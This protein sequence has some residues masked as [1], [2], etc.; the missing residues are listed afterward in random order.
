MPNMSFTTEL[1][2]SST[3]YLTKCVFTGWATKN[4][5][6]RMRQYGTEHSVMCLICSTVENGLS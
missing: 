4:V 3:G 1:W 2:P 6:N 5:G